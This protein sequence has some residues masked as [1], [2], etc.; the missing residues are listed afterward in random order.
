MSC[1][2][3]S[4]S[5]DVLV[6]REGH[7]FTCEGPAQSTDTR[8]RWRLRHGMAGCIGG[9]RQW[10]GCLEQPRL[11]ARV[12]HHVVAVALEAVLVVDDDVLHRLHHST[13]RLCLGYSSA[14]LALGAALSEWTMSQPID[15]IRYS[16]AY[17]EQRSGE[18]AISG[19]IAAGCPPRPPPARSSPRCTTAS[20][21]ATTSTRASLRSRQSAFGWPPEGR[22]LDPSWTCA[23]E[24]PPHF[25]R[26][27]LVKWTMSL[28][29]SATSIV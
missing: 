4:R 23:G 14:I 18:W 27:T 2:L 13:S 22:A 17:R 8:V 24:G 20:S 10:R 15:S 3:S 25:R 11:E 29:S 9:R 5:V 28:S 26:A 19:C 6:E 16:A 7:A 21:A 12:N 1:I